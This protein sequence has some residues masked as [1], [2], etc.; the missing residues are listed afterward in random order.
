MSYNDNNPKH[1]KEL[2]DYL[3]RPGTSKDMETYVKNTTANNKNPG[4]FKK[5]VKE[6][7][8]MEKK[9]TTNNSSHKYC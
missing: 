6:D 2:N 4:T 9:R 8:A 3:T 1:R 7:E 5:L